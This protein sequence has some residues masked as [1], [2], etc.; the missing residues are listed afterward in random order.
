MLATR[1]GS[2]ACRYI[3]YSHIRLQVDYYKL[4]PKTFPEGS[5]F[6]VD[7]KKLR[8][9]Y[10]A[11]QQDV[12]PDML[13]G[14]VQLNN[15]SSTSSTEPPQDIKDEVS[16]VLNKAYS[17]LKSSLPRAQYILKTKADIDLTNDD[18]IKEFQFKDKNLLLFILELHEELENI[19]KEEEL[20]DLKRQNDL[21]IASTELE[22]LLLFD[23]QEYQ[24]AALELVKLKYW[25]NIANA[26][27]NWEYGK[28]VN[29]TH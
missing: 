7:L 9:E 29:L 20:V 14:S 5:S 28:P 12:H 13:H 11:L 19:T 24:Q 6:K 17:T 2:R 23:R 26:I 16:S 25:Y 15:S 3:S 10:R 21:R 4:F 18:Q 27:K 22:L 8:K 1:F